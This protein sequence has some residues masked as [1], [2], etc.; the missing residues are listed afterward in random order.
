MCDEHS[1]TTRGAS[2][3]TPPPQDTYAPA[4]LALGVT[5]TGWGFITAWQ[6]MVCGLLLVAAAAA[7]WLCA[8]AQHTKTPEGANDDEG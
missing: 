6:L 3:D 2:K 1:Q 8:A 7:L 5:V 4:A